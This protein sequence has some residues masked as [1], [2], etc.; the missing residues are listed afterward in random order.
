VDKI[1]ATLAIDISSVNCNNY[2][3]MFEVDYF[4]QLTYPCDRKNKVAHNFGVIVR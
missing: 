2:I 4:S 1:I 3:S